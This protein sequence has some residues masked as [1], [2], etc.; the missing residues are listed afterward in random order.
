VQ[1][2][3]SV[4]ENLLQQQTTY[5][6]AIFR[7]IINTEPPVLDGTGEPGNYLPYQQFPGLRN[8]NRFRNMDGKFL[9]ELSGSLKLTK[10]ILPDLLPL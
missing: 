7:D 2:Q 10:T 8:G 1:L 6:F 9:D 3:Y 5:S 4:L